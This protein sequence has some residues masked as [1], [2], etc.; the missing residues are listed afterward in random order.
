[1]GSSRKHQDDD[2]AR[3]QALI[4]A[5]LQ[6]TFEEIFDRYGKD[7]G[8]EDGVIDLDKEIV[9]VNGQ[10]RNKTSDSEDDSGSVS[11]SEDDSG[12][13]SDSEDGTGSTSAFREGFTPSPV[14]TNTAS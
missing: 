3:S 10:L 5:K 6:S 14:R 12:S 11:D 1:M 13:V 9:L 2:L 7:A 8:D 4:D